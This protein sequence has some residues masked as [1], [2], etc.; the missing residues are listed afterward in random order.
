MIGVTKVEG[1]RKLEITANGVELQ[2]KEL[3]RYMPDG[4]PKEYRPPKPRLLRSDYPIF[5]NSSTDN[6]MTS[7]HLELE[8]KGNNRDVSTY[9]GSPNIDRPGM[10][11]YSLRFNQN[12]YIPTDC[13]TPR[14]NLPR[15]SR[16]PLRSNRGMTDEF[17][18]KSKRPDRTEQ[19][20][21]EEKPM[22]EDS[23]RM[24]IDDISLRTAGVRLA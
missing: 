14:V 6:D 3:D 1:N 16:Y 18:T 4:G 12:R 9:D 11:R 15:S 8:A 21:S 2:P 10:S 5:D 23:E 20:A 24:D 7:D 19:S 13:S 17:G 22:V